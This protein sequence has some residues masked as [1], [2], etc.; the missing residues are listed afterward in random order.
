MGGTYNL[1]RT[2]I[3]IQVYGG[4]P[5]GMCVYTH[6]HIHTH[7]DIYVGQRPDLFGSEQIPVVTTCKHNK[8]VIDWHLKKG[9]DTMPT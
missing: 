3:H 8:G 1:P 6:T 9:P 5:D 2:G 4:R 7:V